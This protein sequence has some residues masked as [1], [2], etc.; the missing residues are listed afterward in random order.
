MTAPQ[1]P[2]PQRMRV[3]VPAVL[4]LGSNLGDR[5]A[6]IRKAVADLDAADGI[7]VQQLSPLIETPALKLT[8]VDYTAPAYLNAVVLVDTVLGPHDL[9]DAV[10]AVEEGHGR[11]RE[12]RWGD[13]TLDIDII[14]YDGRRLDDERLTLPHPRAWERSFV[15]APWHA[16]Q[17]DAELAGHGRID[18]LLTAAGDAYR[19]YPDSDTAVSAVHG[20]SAAQDPAEDENGG[21]V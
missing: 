12:E 13:R 9:L 17:P 19:P 15:L 20:A 1:H 3:S 5:E 2:R 11:V 8:G 10:N 18:L 7:R 16:V 6:T 21:A 14:D 4:A